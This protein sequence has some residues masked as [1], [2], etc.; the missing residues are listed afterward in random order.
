M[1][2]YGGWKLALLAWGFVVV[3]LVGTMV[4]SYVVAKYTIV[5]SITEGDFRYCH[6]QLCEYAESITFNGPECCTERRFLSSKFFFK[7]SS[8]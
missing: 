8:G 1:N 3:A 4:G 5:L 2:T 6:I 7:N